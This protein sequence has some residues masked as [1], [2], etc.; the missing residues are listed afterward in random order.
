MTGRQHRHGKAVM[1]DEDP[2]VLPTVQMIADMVRGAGYDPGELTKFRGYISAYDVVQRVGSGNFSNLLKANGYDGVVYGDEIV[3]FDPGSN[4]LRVKACNSVS[5]R[6]LSRHF[7][8]LRQVQ[9][10][11]HRKRVQRWFLWMGTVFHNRRG[12]RQELRRDHR[13]QEPRKRG[14][15]TGGS[16]SGEGEHTLLPWSEPINERVRSMLRE[17][18]LKL[19]YPQSLH[20]RYGTS[21]SEGLVTVALGGKRNGELAL[22]LLGE[23]FRRLEWGKGIS[24]PA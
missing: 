14:C 19:E 16:T 3:A 9:H 10:G 11:L 23:G 18:M 7:K 6:S 17:P 24:L 8:G 13:Q 20:R 21:T 1:Q 22:L 5:D 15:C 2:G 4:L 12:C